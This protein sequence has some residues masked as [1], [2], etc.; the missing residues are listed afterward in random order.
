MGGGIITPPLYQEGV[1]IMAI[2]GTK[3]FAKHRFIIE[4]SKKMVVNGDVVTI[5]G[6]TIQF[7]GFTYV[8]EDKEEIEKI[9]KNRVFGSMIFEIK[10]T[11]QFENMGKHSKNAHNKIEPPN[12]HYTQVGIAA[13][14]VPLHEQGLDTKIDSAFLVPES[15]VR[16]KRK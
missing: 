13:A 5:P 1:F 8:T 9:R 3:R 15:T 4:R 2:F 10:D 11:K 7:S 6:L 14:N 16:I 12:V